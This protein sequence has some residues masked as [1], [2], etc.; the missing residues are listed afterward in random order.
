MFLNHQSDAVTATPKVH[1]AIFESKKSSL[2][3]S[4]TERQ[5]K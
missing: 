4:C 2:G 3:L 1:K 5:Q